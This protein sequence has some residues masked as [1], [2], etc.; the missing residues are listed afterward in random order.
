MAAMRAAILL[1]CA[2]AGASCGTAGVASER[3]TPP[4][5]PVAAIAPREA[6][7]RL[8]VVELTCHSCAGQVAE[9]TA[10]IPGVLHVSA[11]M[12][13]HMLIVRYDPTRLTESALISAIDKVVDAVAD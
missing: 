4:P 2:L 13:D 1:F 11:E 8:D 6:E 10:R 9:G 5:A 12:L 3:A 7:L